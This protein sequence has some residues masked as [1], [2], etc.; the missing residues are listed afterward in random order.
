M[1]TSGVSL[2]LHL[3]CLSTIRFEVCRALRGLDDKL[4]VPLNSEVQNS[5]S[6]R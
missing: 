1:R 2:A 6:Q 5:N 3:D 4:D